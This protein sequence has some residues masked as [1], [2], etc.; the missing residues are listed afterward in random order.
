MDPDGTYAVTTPTG[1]SRTSRP[2]GMITAAIERTARAGPDP[3][4]F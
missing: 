3:P 2:P 4:P 1:V